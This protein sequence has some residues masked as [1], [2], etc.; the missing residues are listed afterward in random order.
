VTPPGDPKPGDASRAAIDEVAVFEAHRARLLALAYRMLGDVG[1]AEDVVQD[2]WLRWYTHAAEAR[3]PEAYLVTLV[4]RMCLNEL[5]SPRF[6]REEQCRRARSTL[7]AA[8]PSR[9]G[10]NARRR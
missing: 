5:E 4:T 6:R 10:S 9:R 1:R 2:T 7:P 8:R 3:S